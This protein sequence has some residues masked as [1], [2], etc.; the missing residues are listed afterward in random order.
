M[1]CLRFIV[2]CCQENNPLINDWLS[3]KGTVGKNYF[4]SAWVGWELELNGRLK[5]Q[6]LHISSLPSPTVDIS[7]V[8][9][10]GDTSGFS[11]CRFTINLALSCPHRNR[12]FVSRVRLK[13]GRNALLLLPEVD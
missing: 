9:P 11:E 10:L 6:T 2:D 3:N 7:S 12:E 4:S 13:I 5:L 1:S 8:F